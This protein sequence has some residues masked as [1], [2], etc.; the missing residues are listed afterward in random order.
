MIILI[1]KY[2]LELSVV[3][4]MLIQSLIWESD[5]H[6]NTI[7]DLSNKISKGYIARVERCQSKT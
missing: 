3:D 2:K 1:E 7:E 4:A 6:P 5:L